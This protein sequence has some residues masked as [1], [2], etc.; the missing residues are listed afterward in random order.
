MGRPPKYEIGATL[1]TPGGAVGRVEGVFAGAERAV[2]MVRCWQCDRQEE[3][4][5]VGP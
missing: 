2:Q 1:A 3:T 5:G 4:I